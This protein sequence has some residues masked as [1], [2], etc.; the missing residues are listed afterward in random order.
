MVCQKEDQVGS[1]VLKHNMQIGNF[2]SIA[3][4]LQLVSGKNHNIKCINTGALALM[5]GE[6]DP[7]RNIRGGYN[8]KGRL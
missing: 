8:Q 6:K 1:G 5:L 4:N 3:E 2:N 7:M